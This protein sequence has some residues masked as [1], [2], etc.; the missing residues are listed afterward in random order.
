[1]HH[2]ADWDLA[3]GDTFE[4]EL[5]LREGGQRWCDFDNTLEERNATWREELVRCVGELVNQV[6][7]RF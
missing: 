5:L 3:R 2:R 7:I 4:P 1:M 6:V